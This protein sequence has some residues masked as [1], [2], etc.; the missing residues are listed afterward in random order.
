V[1]DTSDMSALNSAMRNAQTIV[2]E[3]AK[4]AWYLDQDA[5]NIAFYDKM[6]Y[7]PCK[8]NFTLSHFKGYP[9]P[10]D[11]IVLHATGS[12]KPWFFRGGHPFS[13]WYEKEADLLGL[14]FF[15]RYDFWWA[16]RRLVRKVRGFLGG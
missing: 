1:F 15:K 11:T 12:R 9:I 4:T 16:P 8:W 10:A 2:G 5:I 14:S 13:A 6:S 3:I 7:L